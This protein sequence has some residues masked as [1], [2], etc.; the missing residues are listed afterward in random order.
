ML[1]RKKS[2]R[3]LSEQRGGCSGQGKE[4]EALSGNRRLWDSLDQRAEGLLRGEGCGRTAEGLAAQR[5][6][7]NGF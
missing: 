7:W 3:R 5:G 2:R 4:M 6:F 1:Y